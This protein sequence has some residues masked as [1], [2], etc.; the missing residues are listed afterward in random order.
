M[1]ISADVTGRE[2]DAFIMAKSV[3]YFAKSARAVEPKW[4]RKKLH[5]RYKIQYRAS[6]GAFIC[7]FFF[8]LKE[9][10]FP[11]RSSSTAVCVIHHRKTV[12]PLFFFFF[13][14]FHYPL[15]QL[16]LYNFL[17]LISAVFTPHV[18]ICQHRMHRLAEE[19]Q[20]VKQVQYCVFEPHNRLL[21][22][23]L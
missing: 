5:I 23:L 2:D 20:S 1:K 10:P 21:N 13:Y 4:V 7:F 15:F 6:A 3:Y 12:S 9:Q 14:H 11:W 22:M 16:H 17:V 19:R 18:S 8:V